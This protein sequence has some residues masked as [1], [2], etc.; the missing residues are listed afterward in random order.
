[1]S[2]ITNLKQQIKELKN[3]ITF[4]SSIKEEPQKY[5]CEMLGQTTFRLN[6]KYGPIHRIDGPAVYHYHG[7]VSWNLNNVQYRLRYNE[8]DDQRSNYRKFT[9]YGQ[10]EVTFEGKN[11]YDLTDEQAIQIV[12]HLFT[13]NY[14]DINEYNEAMQNI[15]NFENR[16]NDLKVFR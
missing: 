8:D 2:Q 10:N 5:I 1:M 11:Y 7:Q 13:N 14:F 15:I 6:D 4:E 16:C 9:P 12:G 3:L